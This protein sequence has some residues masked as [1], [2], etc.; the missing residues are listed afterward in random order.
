MKLINTSIRIRLLLFF[1]LIEKQNDSL[2]DNI[3]SLKFQLDDSKKAISAA[4][5]LKKAAEF[6]KNKL[7]IDLSE[8]K[9]QHDISQN[10]LRN[11]HE[12]AVEDLTRQI[13]QLFKAKSK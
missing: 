1:L 6:E 11:R 12:E 2:L 10:S 7:E 4:N 9:R 8:E 3:E 13:Q 5:D